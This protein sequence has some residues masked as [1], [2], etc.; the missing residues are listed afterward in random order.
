M[1]DTAGAVE[2]ALYA[3]LSGDSTLTALLGAGTPI[4]TLM[5]P[6]GSV[7]Q[8]YITLALTGGAINPTFASNPAYESFD[9]QVKAWVQGSNQLA[10]GT[11]L[12]RTATLLNDYALTV[13]GHTLMQCRF[14]RRGVPLVDIVNGSE[15]IQYSYY[16]SIWVS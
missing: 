11:I 10:A 8:P 13:T 6:S 9:Y 3:R 14:N 15:F 4:Y 5:G 12:D 2:T 16:Y 7:T 1:A